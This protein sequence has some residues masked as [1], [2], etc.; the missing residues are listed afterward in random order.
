MWTEEVFVLTKNLSIGQFAGEGGIS[1][2][3]F[4]E[5]GINKTSMG[6]TDLAYYWGSIGYKSVG[7]APLP[8]G[9]WRSLE[10]WSL[11]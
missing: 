4:V 1:L 11:E 3:Q 6:R 7:I 2:G 8:Y 5:G 9:C 10:Q